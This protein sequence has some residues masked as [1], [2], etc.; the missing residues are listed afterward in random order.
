MLRR[1]TTVAVE[2]NVQGVLNK[3]TLSNPRETLSAGIARHPHVATVAQRRLAQ[4]RTR[5]GVMK[6]VVA[7]WLRPALAVAAA[8]LIAAPISAQ[9][10]PDVEKM[11]ADP[12]NWAMQAGDMQNH[13]YSKLAQIN[14]GNVGKMQ[15][16][17]MFSTGVLR[18][19]EGSPLVMN[20]MMY[21]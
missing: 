15:V 16:A 14:K 21:I 6:I 5:G 13:R 18:C 10:N 8:C 11:I 20:G 17:W 7:P 4:E 19:H 9:A 2:C 3:L 12:N 1:S